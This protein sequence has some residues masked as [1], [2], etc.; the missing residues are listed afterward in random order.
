MNVCKY[1]HRLYA[2][3]AALPPLSSVV[4]CECSI[5]PSGSFMLF[6]RV[7][8]KVKDMHD[9]LLGGGHMGV[10]T[11]HSAALVEPACDEEP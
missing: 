6:T 4:C 7:T 10:C 11:L 5:T 2:V 8:S 9:T 3:N 1:V